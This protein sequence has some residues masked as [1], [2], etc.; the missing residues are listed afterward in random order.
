[1][2]AAGQGQ[3][4]YATHNN[5]PYSQALYCL[6]SRGGKSPNVAVGRIS[7]MTGKYD[8][9]SGARVT[10]GASLMAITALGKAGI[11]VVERLDSTIS[12]I[13]LAYAKDHLLSDSPELA[14]KDPNNYRRVYRGQIAG[15]QYYIVGGVTELNNNIRSS[16]FQGVAGY[17]DNN[18][19]SANA[20]LSARDHVMN[21]AVD[22]RLVDT[23]SQQVI[24]SVS[25]QKQIL[26]KEFDAGL[27]GG[28]DRYALGLSGGAGRLEP[29]QSAVRSMIELG[30]YE[31]ISPLKGSG[32]SC[33]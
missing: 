13:E 6:T 27:G 32:G 8:L 19:L 29:L 26:G 21:V 11:S 1:V 33:G 14:G 24:Q 22:L 9:D 28:D 7:D 4:A 20:Q 17:K 18:K 3:I 25:Y 2:G 16:G 5:T 23:R 10:Q 31:L 15:S 12:E 30:V